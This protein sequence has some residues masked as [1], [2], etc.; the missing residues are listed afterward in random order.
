M[1]NMEAIASLQQMNMEYDRLNHQ[2]RQYAVLTYGCQMNEHDSEMIAGMLESMGYILAQSINEADI[3]II[4]T[5]CVR[6]SAEQK[7]YGKIGSLKKIKE[8]RPHLLIGVSGCMMQKPNELN[9]IRRIAPHVDFVL[10]TDMIHT[11]GNVIL[12]AYTQRKLVVQISP[13]EYRQ[14][15]E[16]LPHS[17]QDDYRA[18]VA[19]MHGCN[20]F[21]TYC[22]V[23]HVR[24]RERSRTPTAIISEITQLTRKGVKE[25]T[26]LGQN[27]NSYGRGLQTPIDFSDLLMMVNNIPNIQRIRFMTS[28]PRDLTEKLIKTIEI[29][30][31]VCEHIHLPAQAGSDRILQ[32]MNRGYNQLQYLELLT[33]IRERIPHVSVTTDIIVGFPGETEDDFQETLKLCVKAQWD[34]AYTFIYSNRSGT[35]ASTMVDQIPIAV[36]KRRLQELMALQNEISLKINQQLLS[37]TLE[38]MVEGESQNDAQTL[39]GRTR[40]HKLVLFPKL[41]NLMPGDIVQVR[42]DEV[43]TWTLHGQV[44][45]Y[46]TGR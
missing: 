17:R 6:E 41:T 8:E 7:I 30:K 11:L 26:L 15:D 16:G 32:L 9:R 45:P 36:K 33:Q 34:T 12:D 3:I 13:D 14:I 19:I 31:H 18:W 1:N 43:K 46:D 24:G 44:V 22:I 39:A 28:H 29:S 5:C 27:V 21:C 37:T 23:P 38:V 25:V 10:G 2:K 40:T 20:N 42:I 4:N 35:T